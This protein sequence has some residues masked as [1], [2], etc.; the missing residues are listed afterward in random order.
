LIVS[1]I[2]VDT[3]EALRMT[4]PNAGAKRRKELLSIRKQLAK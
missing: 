2:V 3:L 1:R 4:Y